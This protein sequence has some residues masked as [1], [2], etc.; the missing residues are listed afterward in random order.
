MPVGLDRMRRLHRYLFA[1]FERVRAIWASP[2]ASQVKWEVSIDPCNPLPVSCRLQSSLVYDWRSHLRASCLSLTSLS[3]L[4][5]CPRPCP[6]PLSCFPEAPRSSQ[7]A[8][9][10]AVPAGEWTPA[11]PA[12]SPTWVHSWEALDRRC[13]NRS[14]PEPSARTVA[15]RLRCSVD[16]NRS[17]REQMTLDK[18]TRP[19]PITSGTICSGRT[20]LSLKVDR[21]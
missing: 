14:F 7:P 12:P 3:D 21:R 17:T 18:F 6:G 15:L 9:C 13:G 19:R 5:P 11:E 8:P 10:T 4:H 16:P 2:A 20:Y 1:V